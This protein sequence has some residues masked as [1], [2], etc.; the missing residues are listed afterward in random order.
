MGLRKIVLQK[1]M[2]CLGSLLPAILFSVASFELYR[3]TEGGSWGFFF[4]LYMVWISHILLSTL[5]SISFKKMT[6]VAT[7]IAIILFSIL[8]L[9]C[10]LLWLLFL[11]TIVLLAVHIMEKLQA[12]LGA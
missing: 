12:E 3:N 2:V 6:L 11:P 4:I 1:M 8:Y 7:L 9:F 10:P 5:C